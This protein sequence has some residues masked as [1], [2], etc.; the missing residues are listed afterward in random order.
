[1]NDMTIKEARDSGEELFRTIPDDPY[2]WNVIALYQVKNKYIL[3][4]DSGCS[5][6]SEFW[7]DDHDGDVYTKTQ[8]KKLVKNWQDGE[9]EKEMK[10]WIEENIK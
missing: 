2:S 9:E 4:Y 1:M 6:T 8:L 3:F 7:M 5:C 10:N